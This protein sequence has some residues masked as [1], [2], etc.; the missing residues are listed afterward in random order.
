MGTIATT[1]SGRVEG[2]SAD[3]IS[4]FRG[5]PFAAPPVGS[6]RWQPPTPET[7][8]SEVRPALEF[9]SVGEQGQ[10]MLEQLM[11]GEAPPMSEDCLTLNVWTPGLDGARPVMV[12]IHGGAFMFG[13]G[14]TPW[15]DGTRLAEH[16]DVV[17][18][19]INYRLGPFGF[20]A[21]G[22]LFDGFEASANL[23][24]LDQ[25]AALQWVRDSIAGFG[26]DPDRVTIFGE[27]AGAGSVGTLLGTPAARG[28]FQQAILQ[29]GAAS[30]GRPLDYATGLARQVLE[31]LGVEPG[32]TEALL[33]VSAEAINEAGTVLGGEVTNARLPWAPT[34]DG[35]VL[36]EPPLDAITNGSTAGVRVLA[37][38]NLDEM[39]LFSLMDPALATLADADIVTRIQEWDPS[40]DGATLLATY[41][42]GRPDASAQD[43]WVAMTSDAVFRIPAI[44]LVEEHLAHG[45]AWMYLFTWPTPV[46]GGVLRS[47]H[48]VEIPFVFDN[49]HQAGVEVF[50]GTGAERQTLAD[51][52]HAAWLAFVR[53]GDPNVPTNPTWPAYDRDRR[54]TMRIDTEWELLHDPMDGERKLWEHQQS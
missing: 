38:T 9:G 23:G 42:D 44:R 1:R 47:T 41:R 18:V 15:Y 5:I 32:D 21:L 35:V 34:H 11:G 31:R 48:A 19:T 45:P 25:V 46:F 50:T 33:A 28:L 43:L 27:S 29:S 39:T 12:W 7:P 54:A 14:R 8:W 10:M 40:L 52:V 2:E 22:E 4:V 13:S 30:W 49:L 26:G 24:I 16:G 3:G 53:T 17:V 37:G 36:P 6:L 20:L 51:R